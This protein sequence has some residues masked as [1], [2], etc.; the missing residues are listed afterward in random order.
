MKVSIIT[1]TFNSAQ[2]IAD[3]IVSVNRQ[4]YPF[5]EH[6]I[7]DGN[8]KDRTLEIINLTP[9]RVKRIIS[10]PDKGIYDAMNK[11]IKVTTGEIVGI[12][13][14]DDF[15]TSTDV[16]DRIVSAFTKNNVDAVYGD[17]CFV[18]SKN[19]NK[20]VRYYSSAWFDPSLF[21]FGFMPAHPSFYVR[22]KCYEEFGLYRID[23]KIAADYELLIRYLNVHKLKTLYLN[24]CVVTMRL[25]GKSTNG[26]KSNWVL[27]KE[28]ISGCCKNGIYTN[29]IILLLKYFI[30]V[31]GYLFPNRRKYK[32]LDRNSLLN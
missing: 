29:M 18:K 23:Y 5:I 30:K 20:V 12:L 17:V 11:G 26:L 32:Y 21:R 22:R 6:I 2:T 28:I 14:S 10:E 25:G 3:C 27:N 24:F 31:T 19:L 9:N 13:N 15:F 7:V 8:S 4:S 1:I 16:I